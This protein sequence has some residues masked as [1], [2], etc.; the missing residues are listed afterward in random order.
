MEMPNST[1]YGGRKQEATIFFLSRS[2]LECGPQEINSR[3]IRL[4][5]TFSG[6]WNKRGKVWITRIL[7]KSDNF[8]SVAVVGAKAPYKEALIEAQSILGWFLVWLVKLFVYNRPIIAN[9]CLYP[10][11]LLFIGWRTVFKI[12]IPDKSSWEGCA[13]DLTVVH[14]NPQKGEFSTYLMLGY[15]RNITRAICPTLGQGRAGRKEKA[16]FPTL[17]T[18]IVDWRYNYKQAVCRKQIKQLTLIHLICR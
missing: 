4:H 1:F 10:F 14:F 3:E 16:A 7:F 2:K 9:A 8:T 5:L 18:M 12:T 17:L 6:K 15:Y 11:S 13:T